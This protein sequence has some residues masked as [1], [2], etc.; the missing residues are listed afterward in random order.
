[1]NDPHVVTLTYALETADTISFDGAEPLRHETTDFE[2][3]LADGILVATPKGDFASV[4]EARNSL[5]PLLHSWALSAAL[6]SGRSEIWFKYKDAEVIDRHPPPPG[7]SR[8]L[9]ADFGGVVSAVGNITVKLN[10]TH[11]PDPPS[12][13]VATPD[14]ESLWH[15]FEGYRSGREPLL[16]M[17]YFCLTFIESIFGGR[18]NAA[19]Q[20][21]FSKEVLS[22]LGELTSTH[23]D[24]TSARKFSVGSPQ[25]PLTHSEAKWIEET[26]RWIIRRL[27]E[28]ATGA[29][30]S[31]ITMADV[32][33]I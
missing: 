3:H 8:V 4:T 23:G 20:L 7:T 9:K 10:R 21:G 13:F 11:Y 22:K 1:M 28:A 25:S 32:E 12:E 17:S 18:D 30:L 19:I 2:L 16:S 14:V 5:D 27:G 26:V 29:P 33:T 31:Q 15:R 6:N 24:T